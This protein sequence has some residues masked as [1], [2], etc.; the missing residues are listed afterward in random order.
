MQRVVNMQRQDIRSCDWISF[1]NLEVVFFI[2][3]RSRDFA[4]G[5]I[6]VRVL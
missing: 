6:L 1:L 3:D 2:T 5:L 4:G